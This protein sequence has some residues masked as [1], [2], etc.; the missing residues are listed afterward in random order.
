MRIQNYLYIDNEKSCQ[1]IC[2]S[3]FFFIYLQY[4]RITTMAIRTSEQLKAMFQQSKEQKEQQR[5]QQRLEKQQQYQQLCKEADRLLKEDQERLKKEKMEQLSTFTKKTPQKPLKRFFIDFNSRW[6]D[7]DKYIKRFTRQDLERMCPNC[8]N[9]KKWDEVVNQTKQ[10]LKDMDCNMKEHKDGVTYSNIGHKVTIYGYDL[11]DNPIGK[12]NSV[13]VA[14]N[15]LNIPRGTICNIVYNRLNHI[16][17]KHK[18]K[19][20]KEPLAL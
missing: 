1:K 12:W 3:Q 15:E 11:D 10:Q 17:L 13:Q 18:I 5:Q 16:S 19:L 8:I 14:A 4:E 9:W 7:D 6:I 20:T 2:F